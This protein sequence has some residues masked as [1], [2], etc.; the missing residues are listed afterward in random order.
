MFWMKFEEK[1]INDFRG[2]RYLNLK[3]NVVERESAA[4]ISVVFPLFKLSDLAA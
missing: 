1:T 2:Y 3:L 4:V